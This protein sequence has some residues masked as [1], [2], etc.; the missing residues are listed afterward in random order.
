MQM[1][2][3]I[4]IYM[5]IILQMGCLIFLSFFTTKLYSIQKNYKNFINSNSQDVEELLKNYAQDVNMTKNETLKIKQA[6]EEIK[7]KFKTSCRKISITRY[8]AIADVG[9]DL[10]FVIALLDDQND[11]VVLNGIY[12]RDGS[13]TYAKPIIAGKSQYRLSPEEALTLEE[14]IMK[15]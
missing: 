10:S 8:K 5:L 15:D 3:E 1:K 2:S 11:G 12:S 7:E 14:A 9:S 4:I 6:V 13:Y